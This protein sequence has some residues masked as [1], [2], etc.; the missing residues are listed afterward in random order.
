MEEMI[1]LKN[2][3]TATF[4]LETT[5]VNIDSD[6]II[7]IAI[8]KRYPDGRTIQRTFYLNPEMDIP[9]EATNVHG[10]T[11]EMV[12]GCKTFSQLAN[13]FYETLKD[14]TL[15]GFNSDNFDIPLI[16]KEF[17]RCGIMFPLPNQKKIDVFSLYKKLYPNTLSAI[18]HRMFNKELESA[19]DATADIDATDAILSKLLENNNELSKMNTDELEVFI[20]GDEKYLDLSRNI[21][22]NKYG[23]YVWNKG[24]HKGRVILD[25][26]PAIIDYNNFVMSKSKYHT[27][28]VKEYI[29]MIISRQI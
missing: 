24:K 22:I 2:D 23:Q 27:E 4:D 6:R 21:L 1:I 3:I 7:Q 26:D 25:D 18:Y 5:G 19:H 13:M 17:R 29:K 14:C 8:T 15:I 16:S 20:N 11:N 28:E 12:S 9:E 10:I